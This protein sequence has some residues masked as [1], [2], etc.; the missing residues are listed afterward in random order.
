[1]TATGDQDGFEFI[2]AHCLAIA[3]KAAAKPGVRDI[4]GE[5]D[6]AVAFADQIT[7]GVKHAIGVIK[8]YLIE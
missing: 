6:V 5:R 8:T 1:M 2:F 7:R 3:F 4:S